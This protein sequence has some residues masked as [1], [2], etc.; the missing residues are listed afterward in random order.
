MFTKHGWQ[1]S[2]GI[3]LAKGHLGSRGEHL[4]QTE[5]HEI[6]HSNNKRHIL[7]HIS[8]ACTVR[9]PTTLELTSISI[10][11]FQYFYSL[12][13]SNAYTHCLVETVPY[14]S[15]SNEGLGQKTQVVTALFKTICFETYFDA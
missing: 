8:C 5:R 14:I 6:Q 9:R 13:N 4:E 2:S 10:L 11:N 1:D 15:T 7:K 3:S 12:T